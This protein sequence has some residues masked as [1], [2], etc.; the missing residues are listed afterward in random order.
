M[1][2]A[3]LTPAQYG[4]KVRTHPAGLLI[5]SLNKMRAGTPME[6]SF[7]DKVIET[8]AFDVDDVAMASNFSVLEGFLARLGEPVPS[9]DAEKPKDI[10]WCGRY[11]ADIIEH[12]LGK[13]K[14]HRD[15]YRV[16]SSMLSKYIKAQNEVG[17]LTNWTV[18]LINVKSQDNDTRPIG[19]RKIGLAQRKA[20][21]LPDKTKYVLPN[22]RIV[23]QADE[24]IG[25]DETKFERA[26]EW[27]KQD[28]SEF[29]SRKNSPSGRN[30][31]KARGPNEG[32]LLIYPVDSS[33][34]NSDVGKKSIPFVGFALSFPPSDKASKIEYRVNKLYTEPDDEY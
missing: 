8:Y 4:L 16:N 15:C 22:R 32:L 19:G 12:F 10:V 1:A 20:L 9:S 34:V 23:S 17:E 5:T 3:K 11:S 25:L 26:K 29:D 18:V 13:I 28:N 6:V 30:L 2:S 24:A 27:T 7:D 21:D 33:I 14:V 31:R